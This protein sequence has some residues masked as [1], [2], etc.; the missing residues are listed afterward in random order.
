[1]TSSINNI[2]FLPAGGPNKSFFFLINLSLSINKSYIFLALVYAEKL[3]VENTNFSAFKLN[4]YSFI[5]T[6]LPVP[7]S[8]DNNILKPPSINYVIK[9]LNLTVSLVYTNILKYG[10]FESYLKSYTFSYHGLNSFAL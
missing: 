4:K 8:P 2:I 7:V 1:M 9:Y 5:I 3:S 10:I 6:V